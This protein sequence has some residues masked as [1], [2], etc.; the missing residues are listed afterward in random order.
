[1]LPS[2]FFFFCTSIFTHA[3]LDHKMRWCCDHSCVQ[4]V[5][6]HEQLQGALRLNFK[7]GNLLDVFLARIG[8]LQ[9]VVK[10]LADLLEN[11]CADFREANLAAVGFREESA[12]AVKERLGPGGTNGF[13]DSTEKESLGQSVA[14]SV[15]Q[16]TVLRT[17]A[18]THPRT[19]A[20]PSGRTNERRSAR[21][22]EEKKWNAK[23]PSGS[24]RNSF[25][26]E[27]QPHSQTRRHFR[28]RRQCPGSD[29]LHRWSTHTHTHTHNS[30]SSDRKKRAPVH[31][32]ARLPLSFISVP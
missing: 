15:L 23:S 24:H 6:R 19:H 1:M 12:V 10:V 20:C 4:V 25:H 7:G 18:R 8:V 32:D 9:L 29:A 27:T 28:K 14:T 31:H 3:D 5:R 30:E 17:G 11:R 26:D 21:E 2:L 16:T 22:K 13:V